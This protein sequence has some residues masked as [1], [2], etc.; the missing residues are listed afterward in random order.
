MLVCYTS[1]SVS[2]RVLG[3]DAGSAGREFGERGGKRQAFGE[4]V[5]GMSVLQGASLF[6]QQPTGVAAEMHCVW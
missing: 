5:L 6:V 4:G 3:A 2:V 1:A